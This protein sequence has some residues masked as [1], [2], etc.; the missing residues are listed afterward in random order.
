M[1]RENNKFLKRIL[2]PFNIANNEIKLKY[3]KKKVGIGKFTTTEILIK[4]L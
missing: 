4:K 2:K 3:K 1:M